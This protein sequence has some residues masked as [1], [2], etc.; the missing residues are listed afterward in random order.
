ME[1]IETQ[2]QLHTLLTKHHTLILFKHSLTC[3]V[4][5]AA[6]QEFQ[7]YMADAHVPA[8]YLYVQE[9]RALSNYIAE[10]FAIRHESP[11]VLYVRNHEVTWHASHWNITKAS[12]KEHIE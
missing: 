8:A 3:P 2:E 1:R 10:Q 4:S 6:F 9:A 12:L 5:H 11:Q 7:A